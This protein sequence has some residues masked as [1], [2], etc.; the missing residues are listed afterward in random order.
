MFC[1]QGKI[2]TRIVLIMVV[3]FAVTVTAG[4][5]M[6]SATPESKESALKSLST[7]SDE[8]KAVEKKDESAPASQEEGAQEKQLQPA[9]T[10]ASK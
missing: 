3:L 4:C 1:S 5:S 10:E 2:V 9:T 6:E 8:D 7:L